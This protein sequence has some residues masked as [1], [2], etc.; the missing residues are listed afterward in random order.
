MNF[1]F[2][3][4]QDLLRDQAR[5][6]LDRN[7]SSAVVRGVLEGN[8][9]YDRKLWHGIAELG[10]PATAIPED[11]GG[12]G[13]SHF[14]LCVIAE[15]L[16]RVLAPVP[17]SS[18][19]YLATELLTNYGSRSQKAIWLPRLA[20]GEV[21]A[22]LAFAEGAGW[23]AEGALT[24]QVADG[25]LSGRKVAVVDG[26]VADI[27]LVVARGG[28]GEGAVWCLV[29]LSDPGVTREPMKVL[30]GTR[31]QATL[32]FSETPAQLVG[33]TGSGW[34]MF[35]DITNR[36]AILFAWEQLGGAQ[37]AFDQAREYALARF[38]F[39]RPI[40]TYQAIKHKLVDIYV[41]IELARANC[42]YGAWALATGAEDLAVAAAAARLAASRAYQTA[43]QEN[44]QI[45]GGMG[46]TWESDCQLHYRRAKWLA[47]VIGSERVWRDRLIDAQGRVNNEPHAAE[48]R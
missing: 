30:D 37:A 17:F 11:W 43:A 25:V 12:L 42:Y 40:A 45:H 24:A 20:S 27:A 6:F 14:E 41:E 4:Q 3:E 31:S 38:A 34:Q 7:C 33:D 18:S 28:G 23:P 9:P 2:S 29:D 48:R 36:A 22:T 8:E 26:E 19:V 46:F 47:V 10:W 39:G 5:G 15:Q 21:I 16:G 32:V 1:E 13:L 44:I 35:S